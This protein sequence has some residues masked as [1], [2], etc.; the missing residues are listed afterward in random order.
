MD[1][2]KSYKFDYVQWL[3]QVEPSVVQ[4]PAEAE[5]LL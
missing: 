2:I 1:T 5:D 4:F 3:L